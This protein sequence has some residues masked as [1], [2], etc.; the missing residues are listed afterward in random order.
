MLSVMRS[1]FFALMVTGVFM[2]GGITAPVWANDPASSSSAAA[3]Y[4]A[5][6][7]EYRK[8]RIR[9]AMAK[10]LDKAD[11]NTYMDRQCYQ[12]E[13]TY[14]NKRI[15]GA[16]K[17]LLVQQDA[18]GKARLRDEERKWIK[19]RDSACVL[20]EPDAGQSEILDRDECLI[21]ETANRATELE[22][23]LS[24]PK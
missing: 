4:A 2:L 3:D 5:A 10:C 1:G 21:S 8:I 13:S 23:R 6:M 14:Q 24:K 20:S 7:A 22:S 18:N 12:I 17:L 16:Y 15:N 9:P 11:A 19:Q